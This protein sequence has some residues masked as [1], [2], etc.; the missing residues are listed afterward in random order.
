MLFYREAFPVFI[1]L[2][3]GWS[4]SNLE[5]TEDSCPMKSGLVLTDEYKGWLSPTRGPFYYCH[6]RK[7]NFSAI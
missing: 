2:S 7:K 5:T 1:T 6:H 4:C 3:V